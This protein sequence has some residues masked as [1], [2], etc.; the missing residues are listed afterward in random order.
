MSN[1]GDY[2]ALVA[3]LTVTF[4]GQTTTAYNIKAL[5]AKKLD[6][7][8]QASALPVRLLLPYGGGENLSAVIEDEP[9][10]GNVV[11][12]SWTF[13]DVL[14]WRPTTFGEG[15]GDS[16]YDLREYSSAYITAALGLDAST[17]SD[18]MTWKGLNVQVVPAYNFPEGGAAFYQGVIATWTV[19]ELSLIHI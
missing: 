8:V 16:T 17:I 9:D 6:D 2:Q 12:I 4:T 3:A 7:S 13:S 15:L 1:I 14:L 11:D 5:D 18:R 19:I 10:I